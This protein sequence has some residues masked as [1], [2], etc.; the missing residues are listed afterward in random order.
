MA[1]RAAFGRHIAIGL[2]EHRFEFG[3]D[4]G[5]LGRHVLLFAGVGVEIEEHHG[6]GGVA[7][8]QAGIAVG[9]RLLILRDER[10][11]VGTARVYPLGGGWNDWR[12]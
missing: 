11:A 1:F 8:A 12:A 10:D 5:M 7:G 6:L 2:V 9:R 3:H 4:I